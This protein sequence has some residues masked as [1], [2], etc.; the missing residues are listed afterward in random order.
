ML[1]LL[2]V[3]CTSVPAL[4][5]LAGHYFNWRGALGRPLSR[6][7]MQV[8]A[9]AFT[10]VTPAAAILY[11]QRYIE[12]TPTVCAALF[13]A[14]AAASNGAACAACA[15]DGLVERYRLLEDQVDR[16]QFRAD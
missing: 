8:W 4:M 12:L 5:I 10:T 11:A 7:E 13:C 15:V 2:F 9:A 3:L 16:A 6:L 1:L 14:A